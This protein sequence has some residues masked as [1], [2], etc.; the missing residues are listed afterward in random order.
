MKGALLTA[1]ALLGSAQAGVHKMKL[2]KIPLDEQLQSVP[3]NTQMERLSQKYMGVRPDKHSEAMFSDASIHV[4][5][6]HPVPISNFMNAQCKLSLEL[7]LAMIA[8]PYAINRCLH[9]M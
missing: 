3:I 9:V 8:L 6:S 7:E 2:Q 1:A 5:G 4:D